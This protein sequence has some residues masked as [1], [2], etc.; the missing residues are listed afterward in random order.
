MCSRRGRFVQCSKLTRPPWTP[1]R[2]SDDMEIS[3]DVHRTAALYL[4]LLKQCLTRVLFPDRS[5]HHDLA[6]TSNQLPAERNEGRDWPTEAETMVGLRRLDN[7]EACA[8]SAIENEIPGDLVE[9]GAWRGGTAILMRA[10]LK[11]YGERRRR[12][13]VADSFQGLP[14]PDPTNYPQDAGDIH[15]ELTPYLGVSLEQ[16]KANFE[17]YGLLDDQVQFL[18]GWFRDTLP[19]APIE[20]IAVLRLDGDMYE[21]TMDGLVN[22]YEKVS[23]GGF[24][25]VDDYGALPNCR[26]AIEDFRR[27]QGIAEPIERIDWTGVFWQKGNAG[28]PNLPHLFER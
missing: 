12:V 24:V 15:H 9:A 13:F 1:T 26:A 28:R 21:S 14:H 5:L 11:A 23:D 3:P 18:P 17:R 25:I 27:A 8:I 16:V 10:V 4:D 2:P 19:V 20:Q 7:L 22:L 6:L